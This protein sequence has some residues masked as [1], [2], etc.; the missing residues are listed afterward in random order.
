MLQLSNSMEDLD[1]F[2]RRKHGISG[3]EH[4]RRI[5]K[6]NE[7]ALR[8]AYG[9]KLR[10]EKEFEGAEFD[11]RYLFAP[12]NRQGLQ[13]PVSDEAGTAVAGTNAGAN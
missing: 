7:F 9:A 10:L 11:W 3:E 1:R 12:P 6:Y 4:I 8:E 13:L 2:A 5:V